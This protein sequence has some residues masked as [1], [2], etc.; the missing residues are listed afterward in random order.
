MIQAVPCAT[1]S[2]AEVPTPDPCNLIVNYIPTP[3]TDEKL[4]ELFAPFGT[5]VSARVI[6]DRFNNH[7]KGYGFVKYTTKEAAKNA[8]RS[9]NGYKI[10]NKHLRVT[11]ANGP[12][13]HFRPPTAE[14]T[15]PATTATVLQANPAAAPQVVH[16]LQ[17]SPATATFQAPYTVIGGDSQLVY[18]Q[19]HTA[20]AAGQPMYQVFLAPQANPAGQPISYFTAAPGA[21]P[22]LYDMASGQP[23]QSLVFQTAP[24]PATP[25]MQDTVF[26]AFPRQSA[27]YQVSGCT[28][29]TSSGFTSSQALTLSNVTTASGGAAGGLAMD[30]TTV[31]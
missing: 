29:S 11:Q 23:K 7:P 22:I 6:V 30:T 25:S 3:V 31:M 13:N 15:G 8:I 4:R 18:S 1:P 2:S 27:T 16:F 14:P 12:Q 19:P 26:P 20:A 21:Q 5:V 9:M 10:G 24:N 17:A 28:G